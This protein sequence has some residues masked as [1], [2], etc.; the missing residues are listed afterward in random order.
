MTRK[1]LLRLQLM[2]LQVFERRPLKPGDS[3]Y[4]VP[5]STELA[6]EALRFGNAPPLPAL[7]EKKL[8]TLL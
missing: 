7:L 8:K 5:I 6:G 2:L 3:L 4:I 1:D